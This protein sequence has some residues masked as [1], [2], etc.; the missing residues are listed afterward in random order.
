M[1]TVA[2]VANNLRGSSLSRAAF[3][4][5]AAALGLVFLSPVFLV[6][7]IAVVIND[8]FPVMF[9]HK[10]VGRWGRP[11]HLLK[12][13]SMYVGRPGSQ[14]TAGGDPRVT[15][16]GRVLRRYKIDEMPQLWNVLRGDMSLIGPRPEAPA[17]V[18]YDDATWQSVLG[19]SPGITDLAS[20]I[21]RDE[22]Q[23]LAG[24][25]AP[26]RHYREHIL[27]D[28]LRLNLHY[29]D[30]SS[31]RADLSLLFWTAWYSMFPAQFDRDAVR[32]RFLPHAAKPIRD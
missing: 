22:E 18:D 26:E 7:A 6:A 1:E 12:F 5:V 16:V 21:Y 17:Y 32:W 10:R 9:R 8:G 15:R 4:K 27:P 20:L 23:V 28:K 25:E 11:F 31:F 2:S 24:S 29:M 13:R 3:D 14:I 30:T 19:V